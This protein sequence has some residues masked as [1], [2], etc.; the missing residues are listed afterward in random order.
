[1]SSLIDHPV[2]KCLLTQMKLFD[3][4][5]YTLFVHVCLSEYLGY[6]YGKCPK[7]FNTLFHTF[8]CL[9]FAFYAFFFFLKFLSG[10]ANSVDTDQTAPSGAVWSGSALFVYAILSDTWVYKNIRTITVHVFLFPCVLIIYV[11]S[12]IDEE[13]VKTKFEYAL[14]HLFKA[15]LWNIFG[16]KKV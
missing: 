13:I 7:I 10:M 1:M 12:V 5:G 6:W 11:I 8:F 16:Y 3:W 14:K 4:S 9:N 2:R 15:T